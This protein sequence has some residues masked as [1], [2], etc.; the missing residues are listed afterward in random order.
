[1]IDENYVTVYRVPIPVNEMVT[2]NAEDDGYTVYINS[3]LDDEHAREAYRHALRHIENNDFQRD[4]VQEIE[5][6]AHSKDCPRSVASIIDVPKKRKRRRRTKYARELAEYVE[7]ISSYLSE[8]K[9]WEIAERER[10]YGK[11]L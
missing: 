9:I 6:T 5:T 1:M 2:P 8:E 4:S 11:Y 10:L 7:Y 3:D